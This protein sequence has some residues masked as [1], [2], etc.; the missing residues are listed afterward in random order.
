MLCKAKWLSKSTKCQPDSSL[1]NTSYFT[2]LRNT[3]FF[4]LQLILIRVTAKFVLNCTFYVT[5]SFNNY[6]AFLCYSKL[7]GLWK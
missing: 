3:S 7:A 1:Q 6:V 4:L 2:S 5:D